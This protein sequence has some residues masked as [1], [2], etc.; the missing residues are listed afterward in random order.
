VP[1]GEGKELDGP[2]QG[3]PDHDDEERA[4]EHVERGE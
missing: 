4:I 3:R 1:G 2:G